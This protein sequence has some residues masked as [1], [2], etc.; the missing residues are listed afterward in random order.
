MLD[1]AVT[2]LVRYFPQIVVAVALM[3]VPIVVLDALLQPHGA[4]AFGDMATLFTAHGPA[5]Q[6]AALE[7]MEA[8][9]A[10]GSAVALVLLLTSAISLL[11]FNA[12]TAV[13]DAALHGR[14]LDARA[15]YA[16]ATRRWPAQVL[17]GLAFL[18]AGGVAAVAL[19]VAYFVLVFVI[20]AL[21]AIAK[22][23]TALAIAIGVIVGIAFLAVV[24]AVV[25]WLSM[26]YTLA[27]I[28][29]VVEDLAAGAA[30]GAGFRRAFGRTTAVRVLLAGLVLDALVLFGTLPVLALGALVSTLVHSHPLYYG[31]S[32]VGQIL[33]DALILTFAV[34]FA[35]DVRVRR[36]GLDLLAA[37][38]SAPA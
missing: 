30:I 19:F 14:K 28:S 29:V 33:I 8:H 20:I 21:A 35:A 22:S 18:V 5:A 7:Q 2:L 31:I 1:R 38:G 36:E 13:V 17:V 34:V 11:G 15:A 25:S 12:V 10:S 24:L 6:R 32:A 9:S 23:L 3:I 37:A 4:D 27:A 16:L 26:A